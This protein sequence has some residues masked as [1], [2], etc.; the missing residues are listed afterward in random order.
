[1][2]AGVPYTLIL[3]IQNADPVVGDVDELPTPTDTMVTIINPRTRDG[4]DVHLFD[5]NVTSIMFPIDRLNFIEILS[6]KEHEEIIGFVR[7]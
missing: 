6:E 1:V 5:E 3:H 7:E 4:K 2:E